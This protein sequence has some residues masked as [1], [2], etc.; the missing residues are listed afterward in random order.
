MRAC[1]VN[2][3]A[4]VRACGVYRRACV[5]A[6]GLNNRAVEA[7][8]TG[9]KR[10]FLMFLIVHVADL[11]WFYVVQVSFVHDAYWLARAGLV[12]AARCHGY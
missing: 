4:Y 12:P 11:G 7:R 5:H 6:C 1:V 8:L 9:V 10:V 3:R 2:R